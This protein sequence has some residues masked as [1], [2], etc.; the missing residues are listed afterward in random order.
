MNRFT[1]DEL[2]ELIGSSLDH[3]NLEVLQVVEK[4]QLD[5]QDN[6]VNSHGY[7]SASINPTN[8]V[9]L[10]KGIQVRLQQNEGLKKLEIRYLCI[11]RQMIQSLFRGLAKNKGL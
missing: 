6:D 1:E 10:C 9:T 4:V 2:L 7:K 3:P 5:D 11:N 8:K